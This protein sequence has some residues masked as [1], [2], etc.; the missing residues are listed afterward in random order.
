[1]IHE[2]PTEFI[3][4]EAA[5][6]AVGGFILELIDEL[7]TETDEDGDERYTDVTKLW[8]LLRINKGIAKRINA[9]PGEETIHEW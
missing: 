6:D 4:R 7:P 8:M 9:I 2:E 5:I 1:M 3:R